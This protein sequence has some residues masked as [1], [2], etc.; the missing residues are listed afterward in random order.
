MLLMCSVMTSTAAGSR[1]SSTRMSC[2]DRSVGETGA[3][4]E[5]LDNLEAYFGTLFVDTLPFNLYLSKT[6]NT[7][8]SFMSFKERKFPSEK[9]SCSRQSLHLTG[10]R[11]FSFCFWQIMLLWLLNK[12]PQRKSS[13]RKT[14][15][16]SLQKQSKNSFVAWMDWCRENRW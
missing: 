1:E 16:V 11:V 2:R 4:H 10:C 9:K 12:S 7:E 5:T 3:Q 13:R 8:I 6:E 15:L 14:S